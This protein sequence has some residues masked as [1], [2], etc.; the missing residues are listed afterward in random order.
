VRYTVASAALTAGVVDTTIMSQFTQS[1][2]GAVARTAQDK[3]REVVSVKD[4][5]AVGDGVTDD[6]AAIQAALDYGAALGV[7]VIAS[8]TFKTTSK[9]TI[10][11]NADF[12]D[13]IL[14][15]YATPLIALE[16]SSGGAENPTTILYNATVRLPKRIANMTK[17][18]VGW[19]LQGVGVRTVNTYACHIF[20]GNIK[21]FQTGLL[22]TSYNTGSV[23]N[24]Y[25]LGNLENNQENLRLE[26]GNSAAWVNSNTYISG[27]LSFYSAEGL[28]VPGCYHINIPDS[29][30]VVNNNL[31]INLSIEGDTPEFHVRCAG[32]FNT[33]QQARWEASTPKLH[34]F[35]SS[36]NNGTRNFVL[37]GYK[38]DNIEVTHSGVTGKNN[39]LIGASTQVVEMGSSGKPLRFQNMS[40]SAS[41]IRLYYEAGLNPWANGSDWSVSESSLE[42]K[43]KRST[44]SQSRLI[45]DYANGRMYVGAGSVAPTAYIGA[46]GSNTLGC[47]AS[48]WPTT[49]NTRTLGDASFRWSVVYAATGTIN[50][51]D[52][53]DKQDVA[54]LS[55][56]EK[57]VALALKGLIKK[58][59]F[60]DAVEVKA[61]DARIHVGVIAQEV[62]AAFEA[63]GLDPMRYGIICYDEWA[64]E[65][66][67][68]GNEMRTAGNRYGVRYEELLAFILAAL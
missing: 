64:A 44:D 17:P 14:N 26:P 57:R 4:F 63:D 65:L 52:E 32:S 47:S 15:V 43:A 13:A 48:V 49:D 18:M 20:V 21:N 54:D 58:F 29:T 27:G 3:M 16:V 46:L 22:C 31:F 25:F 56:A 37:G 68:D 38:I 36:T 59:R 35:G 41:A 10:K 53:R 30:N 19:S 9:V 24:T 23:F 5:G 12:S 60:K 34:F 62:I 6:T 45:L 66:D 8:G 2:T 28:N 39:S 40:S 67:E 42:L 61:D 1:G 33:F 55:T 7:T 50:T 51:S 11:G